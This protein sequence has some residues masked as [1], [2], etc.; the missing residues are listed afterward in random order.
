MRGA[1]FVLQTR[2]TRTL[3]LWFTRGLKT[4]F[5]TLE[6]QPY[7]QVPNTQHLALSTYCSAPCN[8]KVHLHTQHVAATRIVAVFTWTET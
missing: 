6:I 4:T 1:A 5:D 8:P 7:L 3:S 2:S